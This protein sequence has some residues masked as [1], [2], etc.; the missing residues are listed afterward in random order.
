M[1]ELMFRGS[2]TGEAY[3]AARRNPSERGDY[4]DRGFHAYHAKFNRS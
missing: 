3:L 4:E 1:E 2:S